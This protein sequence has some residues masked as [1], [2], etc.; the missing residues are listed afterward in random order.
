MEFPEGRSHG[1]CEICQKGIMRLA[2]PGGKD[3]ILAC[4]RCRSTCLEDVY[5]QRKHDWRGCEGGRGEKAV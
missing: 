2:W 4:D 5:V 1:R 3:N